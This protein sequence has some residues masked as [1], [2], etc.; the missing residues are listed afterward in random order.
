MHFLQVVS[1]RE[2][3]QRNYIFESVI[4]DVG[5]IIAAGGSGNAALA[6]PAMRALPIGLPKVMVT[7]IASGDGSGQMSIASGRSPTFSGA[8]AGASNF[9]RAY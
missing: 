1:F 9:S 7:T 2:H 4:I 3:I 6:T 5:G 8:S